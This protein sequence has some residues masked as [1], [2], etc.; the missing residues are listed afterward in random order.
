MV[1]N[2]V[3]MEDE[4]SLDVQFWLS[5]PASARIAELTRLRHEYYIWLIGEF[6]SQ[7]EKTVM[8]RKI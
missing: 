3:K 1:A 4:D 2:K 8:R 7:M 6:P 5:Q